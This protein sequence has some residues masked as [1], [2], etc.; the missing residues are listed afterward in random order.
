MSTDPAQL[1][2]KQV[3][4]I[5]FV[6]NVLTSVRLALGIAFPFITPGWRWP[7]MLTAALTEFLDGQV[8]RL[9][10]VSGSAGR[11]L[12]PIADKLFVVSV[13]ATL[14]WEGMIALWQLIPV[15]ARDLIVTTGALWVA[16]RHGPT[17]LR[18][19]PPSLLGKIATAAQ[20]ILLLATVASRRVDTVLLLVASLLSVV[21][22]IDYVR[23]FRVLHPT[24]SVGDSQNL[25]VDG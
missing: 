16:V 12:D 8:A 18:Q 4:L 22:G 11:I 20:F 15:I 1:P 21:A 10:G 25:N 7:A 17:A 3:G 23:R 2:P 9:L 14:L 24:L 5:R 6:P 19:M 13:L